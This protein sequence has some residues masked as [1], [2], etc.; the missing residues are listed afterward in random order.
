[1]KGL[2]EYGITPRVKNIDPKFDEIIYAYLLNEFERAK[3]IDMQEAL[4][5]KEELQ[6]RQ[7]FSPAFDVDEVTQLS[8]SVKK[9]ERPKKNPAKKPLK[10]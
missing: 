4:S 2:G 3:D 9:K 1:M 7:P 5:I 8:A 6:N 10:K